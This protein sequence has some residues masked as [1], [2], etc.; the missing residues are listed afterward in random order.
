MML[1]GQKKGR[2]RKARSC[3]V[4]MDWNIARGA[5]GEIRTPDLLVR[6]QTLYP[7]ELRAHAL[8]KQDYQTGS[9]TPSSS[10]IAVIAQK[11]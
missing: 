1:A 11:R 6:S 7:T 10:P 9:K 2:S 5:R 4:D 3:G 8:P